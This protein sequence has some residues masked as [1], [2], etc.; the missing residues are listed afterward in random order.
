MWPTCKSLAV[1]ALLFVSFP[2]HVVCNRLDNARIIRRAEQVRDSYDYVIAGGGT[3]GLTVADRLS[4]DGKCQFCSEFCDYQPASDLLDNVLVVENGV[5]NSDPQILAGL[6]GLYQSNSYDITSVPQ[7]F[8][9][10]KTQAVVVGNLVG[11]SSA[12]NGMAFM[13]GTSDEYDAWKELGGPNST[14]DW[15]G[16]LPY[17]KKAAYFTP[18]RDQLAKA[19]NMTFDVEAAWGQDP[20]TRIYASFAPNQDPGLSESLL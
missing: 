16:V 4:E 20:K 18:P 8:M 7:V 17:F 3:A 1:V 14:W 2:S 13:R 9:N 6:G 10:N 15:A 5:L 12:V 19:F 11:G